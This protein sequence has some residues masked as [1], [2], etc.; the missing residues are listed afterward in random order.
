MQQSIV[1]LNLIFLLTTWTFS[2]NNEETGFIHTAVAN[3]YFWWLSRVTFGGY[4]WPLAP[5]I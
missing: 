2:P 4:F 5:K 3:A 1:F